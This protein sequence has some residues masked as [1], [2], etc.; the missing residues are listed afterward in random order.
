VLQAWAL[1]FEGTPAAERWVH[2]AERGTI[3]GKMPDGSA[4]LPAAVAL[5]RALI[6]GDGPERM[7][8][9]ATVAVDAEPPESPWRAGSLVLLGVALV[10]NGRLDEA[11]RRFDEGAA[12]AGPAQA[13]ASSTAY[14]WQALL[15]AD[16]GNWDRAIVCIERARSL[17]D[18]A[19]LGDE[20]PQILMFA[21]SALVELH[22]GETRF[23]A[24]ELARA[25]RLRPESSNAITWLGVQARLVMARAHVVSDDIAAA[26]TMLREAREIAS[27]GADVGALAVS[28]EE[29]EE[30]VRTLRHE[31]AVG[32]TTLTAA[33][34]RILGLLPTHLS[35]RE[36][37]ARVF[38]SRNTVKTQAISVYRKLHVTSRSEA[39]A[40][41]RELGLLDD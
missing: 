6:A 9:D 26:R 18:A 32:S 40:R 17:A 4:S 25:H 37:A 24:E 36:I 39:V 3:S 38:V 34:L 11:S 23:A 8:D 2:I 28:L 31:G 27:R 41:G 16:E 13:T 12:A 29:L 19:G 33:E 20:A 1:A 7:L 15:A 21:T 22:R 30:R 35:F 14:T 10:L 5:V